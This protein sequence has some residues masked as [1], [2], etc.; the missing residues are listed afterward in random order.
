MEKN[1]KKPSKAKLFI[2]ILV[3]VIVVPIVFHKVSAYVSGIMMA[4]VMSIIISTTSVV[5][6]TI[7]L[8]SVLSFNNEEKK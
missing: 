1:D 7:Y 5:C 2:G 3:L 4:K 6:I 8:S